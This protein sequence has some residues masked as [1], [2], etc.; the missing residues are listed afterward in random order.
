[1]L[2][3]DLNTV[4]EQGKQTNSLNDTMNLSNA[5]NVRHS[6]TADMNP[7]ASIDGTEAESHQ[8]EKTELWDLAIVEPETTDPAPVS[9]YDRNFLNPLPQQVPMHILGRPIEVANTTISPG[10]PAFESSG[11]AFKWLSNPA[12]TQAMRTFD[13]IRPA[14]SLK[15]LMR[16]S[17]SVYGLALVYWYY[18]PQ[19]PGLSQ[20]FKSS[21]SSHIVDIA[22][23]EA[24]EIEIPYV[25]PKEFLTKDFDMVQNYFTFGITTLQSA[26]VQSGITP[27]YDIQIFL[28]AHDVDVGGYITAQSITQEYIEEQLEFQSKT[29]VDSMLLAGMAAMPVI[30]QVA[31]VFSA[32]YEG[33]RSVKDT[34]EPLY[35][36]DS[37]SQQSGFPLG[38]AAIGT[39]QA[40]F[41][42]MNSLQQQP[43]MANLTEFDELRRIDSRVACGKGEHRLDDIVAN[44]TLV[45]QATFD[46][47]VQESII[48][49]D[50]NFMGLYHRSISQH[51]RYFRGRPS[52]VLHFCTSPLM[53]A[54]FTIQ[55][56]PITFPLLTEV[57]SDV[58]SHTVLVR[59]VKR[60]HIEI[61]FHH[62]NPI[63]TPETTEF[64]FLRIIQTQ[65]VTPFASGVTPQVF[66]VVTGAMK[67]AQYF[68]L[69]CA[70]GP[71]KA[72]AAVVEEKE[73]DE[74][75]TVKVL[76]NKLRFQSLR[77]IHR[78]EPEISFCISPHQKTDI[79]QEVETLEAVCKRWT[80][81]ELGLTPRDINSLMSP[82][83]LVL[84][85][86]ART[87]DVYG[88]NLDKF[89][90]YFALYRGGREFRVKPGLTSGANPTTIFVS[91]ATPEPQVTEAARDPANGTHIIASEVTLGEV[92]NVVEYV[93]P[94][95]NRFKATNPVLVEHY[96]EP[97]NTNMPDEV[98]E[99]GEPA[100][101]YSR[102]AEDLQFFW[103]NVINE[104]RRV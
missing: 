97:V 26:T 41:G 74:E 94:Y 57:T 2:S 1:M 29:G 96:P 84:P 12:I 37:S 66:L 40:Y 71:T 58:P 7:G 99:T 31:G 47:S 54:R 5:I 61:P 72:P 45:H 89:Q 36:G 60:V 9:Q 28:S 82:G 86:A 15:L 85:T 10:F 17:P 51:F 55:W 4:T 43:Q 32:M 8:V 101:V 62:Q 22:S 59:G 67:H 103:L 20:E 64:G 39:K 79:Y 18:G 65:A 56:H 13:W 44:G 100:L 33:T 21:A 16:A 46:P 88:D 87:D 68:S 70:K 93:A 6:K 11:L 104:I 35:P 50:V 52:L 42:N 34:H 95:L 3:Y 27:E 81:R 23:A 90:N 69:Q 78:I 25:H 14:F 24:T 92:R 83:P 19:K 30:Q 76:R 75:D 49:L 102:A 73:A 48:P 38:N 63:T 80:R 91:M 53:A 77:N 98:S